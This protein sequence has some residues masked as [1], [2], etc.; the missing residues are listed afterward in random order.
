MNLKSHDKLEKY[1]SETL[2]DYWNE[3]DDE[4]TSNNND[5]E[6][7]DRP[8]KDDDGGSEK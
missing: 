6:T 4:I 3:H 5:E 1:S 8:L 2:V 7:W